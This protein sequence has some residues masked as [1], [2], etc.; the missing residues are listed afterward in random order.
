MDIGFVFAGIDQGAFDVGRSCYS[1]VVN[2]EFNVP[3]HFTSNG[4]FAG[5]AFD[6]TLNKSVNAH[7][8]S[9]KEQVT[10]NLGCAGDIYSGTGSYKVTVN[11]AAHIDSLPCQPCR[12]SNFAV[13]SH[14]LPNKCNSAINDTI[15][16]EC[17]ANTKDVTIYGAIDDNV[18]SGHIKVIV[19]YLSA[20]DSDDVSTAS[21]HRQNRRRSEEGHRYGKQKGNHP[22]E[23]AF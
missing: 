20:G 10:A 13:H 11:T 15:D 9:T 18:T 23:N 6:I 19:D 4:D 14:C 12:T 17:P 16:S 3:P 7:A 2:L 8:S 5:T 21:V 1:Q 22:H